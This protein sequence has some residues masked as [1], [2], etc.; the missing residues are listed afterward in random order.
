MN[1]SMVS[2]EMN[3]DDRRD[4]DKEPYLR[5]RQTELTEI[6]EAIDNIKASSYWKILQTKIFD[7]VARSLQSK[8]RSETNTTELFRLQG[9]LGWADKFCD[10]NKLAKVYR[11]E[12]EKVNKQLND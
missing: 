5:A 2:V 9:Q 1:N 4:K 12:L 3:S 6:I 11:L 10:F 7:D 8:I